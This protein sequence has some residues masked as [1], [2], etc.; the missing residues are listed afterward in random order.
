LVVPEVPALFQASQEQPLDMPVEV[1]AALALPIMLAVPRL[2]GAQV[3]RQHLTGALQTHQ[4]IVVA[5]RAVCAMKVEEQ[6]LP[7]VPAAPESSSSDIYLVLLLM[8]P[9]SFQHILVP[10]LRQVL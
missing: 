6:L 1:V 9:Q 4:P 3:V 8:V 5:V 7:L 10:P 2:T